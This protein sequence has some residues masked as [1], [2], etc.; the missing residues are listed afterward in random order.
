MD[1]DFA[2]LTILFAALGA[3]AIVKGATGM[4]LPMVALPVLTSA[5][6]LQHAIAIMSITQIITNGWQMWQFR[7]ARSDVRLGFL[8]LFLALGLIGVVLGTWAL[9]NLPERVLVMSLGVVLLA[10]F[11]LKLTNPHVA[12]NDRNARRFGPF[13]GFVSGACQGATGL[14]APVG[15]TF[16][17]AMGLDRA[18]HLFAVSAMFL[19]FSLIQ[20]PALLLSGIMRPEWILESFLAMVPILIFMPVGQFL[21]GKLSRQAFDRMILIFLGLVGLKMVLG[22]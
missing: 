8:P 19:A 18:S 22:I 11:V 20:L 7:E 3:G 5:F 14:S 13:V 16:M 21:A 2:R 6:G 15:V 10:Y 1:L 9:G 4:G 17:H 12:V